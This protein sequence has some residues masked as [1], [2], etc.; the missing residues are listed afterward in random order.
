MLVVKKLCVMVVLS[1]S[2]G[3]LVFFMALFGSFLLLVVLGGSSRV[4]GSY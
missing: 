3:F 4:L 1:G 2:W